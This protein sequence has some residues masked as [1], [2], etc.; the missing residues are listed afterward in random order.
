MFKRGMS[1]VITTVLIILFSIVAVA[2]VGGIILYQINKAKLNIED[3]QMCTE[4][5]NSL[6]P[7]KCVYNEQAAVPA[8][9]VMVF[10]GLADNNAELVRVGMRVETLEGAVK[11]GTITGTDLPQGQSKMAPVFI[12]STDQLK[13]ATI[14]PVFKGPS[15]KEVVCKQY[16]EKI[17]CEKRGVDRRTLPDDDSTLSEVLVSHSGGIATSILAIQD[18]GLGYQEFGV[19]TLDQV[20]TQGVATVYVTSVGSNGQITSLTLIDGGSEWNGLTNT[21]VR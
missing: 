2:V 4:L 7:L 20:G 18:P 10:R 19:Q 5:A 12:V 17:D 6:K 13:S 9:V 16:T 3:S 21:R 11:S 15:G 1:G 14:N 8:A